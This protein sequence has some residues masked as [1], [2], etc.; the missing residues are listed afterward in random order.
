MA[1]LKNICLQIVELMNQKYPVSHKSLYPIRRL[2]SI[3]DKNIKLENR[4][5]HKLRGDLNKDHR[6]R[7]SILLEQLRSHYDAAVWHGK[8]YIS[9]SEEKLFPETFPETLSP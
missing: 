3:I 2:L 1:D 9:R 4:V 5:H 8:Y 6:Q 7:L